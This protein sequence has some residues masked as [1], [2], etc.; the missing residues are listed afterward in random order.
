[1]I[2][3]VLVAVIA[4]A[5]LFQLIILFVMFLAMRKGMKLA[6]EYATD[7]QS[8]IVPILEHSKSLIKVTRELIVKLEP[9]LDSTATDVANIAHIANAEA[10]KMQVSADE[11]TYRIRRQAERVDGLTTEA[12]NTA[13]YVGQFVNHAVSVPL[14]QISGVVAAARAIFGTLAKS[15]PRDRARE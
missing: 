6:G 14:R 4:V 12:L 11:I 10:M 7:M 15:S 9:K 2:L 3:T 13:E 8:H 5:G 1:M